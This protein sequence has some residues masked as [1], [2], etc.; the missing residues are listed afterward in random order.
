MKRIRPFVSQS[1][2]IPVYNALIQP[3]LNY[4]SP[5]WNGFS[6][7]LTDKLQKLQNRVARVIA[8]VL[9]GNAEMGFTLSKMKKAKG[10][11]D[12]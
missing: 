3:H 9:L 2:A 12:V 5:I 4:C 1:T 11:C 7:Q 10:S 8:S 6:N